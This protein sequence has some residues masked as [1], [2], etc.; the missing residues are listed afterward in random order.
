MGEYEILH[1]Y[2][3][4]LDEERLVTE[5]H[6]TPECGAAFTKEVERFLA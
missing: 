1:G 5:L 6:E 3:F 2:A 4:K